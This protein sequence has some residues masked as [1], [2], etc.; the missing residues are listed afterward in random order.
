MKRLNN[1]KVILIEERILVDCMEFIENNSD[2]I[3]KTLNSLINNKQCSFKELK[4]C[5]EKLNSIRSIS[6]DLKENKQVEA[7]LETIWD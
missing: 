1:D 6:R 3:Y 4:E 7:S 2:S 5:L